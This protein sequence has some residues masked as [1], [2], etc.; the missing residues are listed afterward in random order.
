MSGWCYV[1]P[2]LNDGQRRRIAA[3]AGDLPVRYRSDLDEAGRREAFAG[4]EVIVGEPAPERLFGA[5][6]LRWLQLTT[7][8]TDRYTGKALPPAMTLTCATGVYGFVIAEYLIGAALAVYRH[9]PAYARQQEKG[10]WQP[11][12]PSRC[13]FGASALV[14]GTGD[15]GATFA[16]RLRAF[17]PREILGVRRTSA[18]PLPDFDE[19]HTAEDLP[20]LWGRADL[21]VGCLPAT[22]ATRHLVGEEALRAMRP[23]ALLLNVGRGSLVDTDALVRVLAERPGMG[24]VLDVT[25]PEPLPP[26]HPLWKLDNVLIT[27]HVAGIGFGAVPETTERIVD[28]VCANLRRYRSGEPLQSVVDTAAGYR[29]SQ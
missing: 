25:D 23:D 3:A 22:A 19:V 5:P 27:P 2:D 15:L 6:R 20:Q 28:L 11:C 9:I 29:R 1:L 17:G 13:L 8:G 18:A 24:A 7:A 4:A 26:E 10:L 21:V 12:Q 14:L 16:R